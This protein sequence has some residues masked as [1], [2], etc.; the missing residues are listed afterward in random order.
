M[1]KDKKDSIDLSKYNNMGG[2]GLK[3]MNFGLWLSRNRKLF[4]RLVIAALVLLSAFFFIYSSYNY[5]VYFLTGKTSESLLELNNLLP[6]R[7]NITGNVIISQPKILKSG[8]NYDVAVKI[9][10]PN[11]KFM[12]NFNYCFMQGEESVSCGQNFILPSE[13]KYILTLNEVLPQESTPVE[14][15]INDLFW[16]RI[17]SHS[18]SNWSEF[19]LERFNFSVDNLHF[20][21]ASESGLSERLSLNSLEF[22]IY[23]NSSYGFH[24]VPLN[25]LLYNG[26][27]LVGVNRYLVNNLPAGKKI[28]VR[29]AWSESLPIISRVEVVPEVNILNNEVYLKY[30]GAG[31]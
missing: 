30:Q 3:E 29:I 25:I 22:N 18:I 28:D 2:V 24:E 5:V 9:S 19:R 8:Q 14:F 27:E 31:N 12:A 26:A 15:I 16:Q 6:S 10:N 13:E 4:F 21:S 23:N 7:R 1:K 11:E 20:A 17:D